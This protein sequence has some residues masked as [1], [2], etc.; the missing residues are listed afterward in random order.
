MFSIG[1]LYLHLGRLSST[2]FNTPLSSPAFIFSIPKLASLVYREEGVGGFFRGL[3]IPL[4][5]ISIVREYLRFR[6][7]ND[8][9]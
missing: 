4:V 3:W 8:L 6:L 5:T 2:G 7:D 1:Q 9:L